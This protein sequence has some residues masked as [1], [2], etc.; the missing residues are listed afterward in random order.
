MRMI[1]L[2]F[3]GL[4]TSRVILDSL[5]AEDYGIYNV[6]GGFVTMF[7]VFRAGVSSATQRYITYDLGKGD[8]KELNR[9]FSTCIL[10]YLMISVFILLVSEI[11]G[12]WFLENKMVIPIERM[13]AAR[14]VFQLSIITLLIGMIS[15]PYNAL[16]IS[17]ER[18][19]VFAYISIFEAVAKLAVSYMIYVSPYD[20]LIVYA[21]LLCVI[22]IAVRFM[23]SIYCS[24]NFPESKFHFF[25]NWKK[26]K[27]IYG[28]T[29]WAMFGGISVIARTQGLNM[30]LNVFF[31][32][33]VNAARGVAVQVQHAVNG[34]V[35]NFQTAL[36]P[37]IVKS[38]AQKEFDSMYNLVYRSSKFSY[39]LLLI[40]SMPIM[41]ETDYI[42]NIWLKEVPNY[43]SSFIRLMFIISMIDTISNPLV[44]SI[45]ATGIIKKYQLIVGLMM[46]AVLPASYFVLKVWEIP[47]IVYITTIVISLIAMFFRILI[48]CQQTGMSFWGYIKEVL[49]KIILATVLS[50]ILPV[51]FYIWLPYSLTRFFIVAVTSVLSTMFFSYTLALSDSERKTIVKLIVNK[52]KQ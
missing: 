16:I 30:I 26:I 4:F 29:G 22:Q 14:W 45:E 31:G 12:I 13:S 19:G 25:V 7:N 47:E 9:T 2:L 28:F 5:G 6:V 24:R 33:T 39:L 35:T 8:M 11:G 48:A 46:I 52:I 36:N 41:L 50:L 21:I 40:M 15:T 18:M 10:I 1:L 42:L 32:P 49:I 44:R 43:T 20:K 37:Q 38:Y 34:F 23:Y 17:H 51:I 27:E 3:V